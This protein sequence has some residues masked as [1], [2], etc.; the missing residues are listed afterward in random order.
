MTNVVALTSPLDRFDDVQ[1]ECVQEWDQKQLIAALERASLLDLQKL[2]QVQ[3]IKASTPLST[4]RGR[5]MPPMEAVENIRI[6]TGEGERSVLEFNGVQVASVNVSD[7]MSL[8]EMYAKVKVVEEVSRQSGRNVEIHMA[9]QHA[10]D[11]VHALSTTCGRSS[12]NL[13]NLGVVVEKYHL[14]RRMF[15]RVQPCYAVKSNP[16]DMICRT[17]HVAGAGFDCASQVELEQVLRLPGV[18]VNDI[19]FAN[20]CKQVAHIEYAKAHGVAMM[21][22]DNPYELEKIHRVYPEAKL[23]LRLLPDDSH[24]L[25]PFGSKFGASFSEAQA[26]IAQCKSLGMS[27][28]GVS[29]HVGS[30]CY[31]SV[32]WIEALKLS[33]QVFDEAK[34]YGYYMTLVDMGGGFPG[35]ETGNLPLAHIG[36]QVSPVI[37]QLF[38]P[39]IRVIAEPGRFFCTQSTTLACTVVS[40]R[41]RMVAIP[42]CNNN[43]NNV[44][45]DDK[46]DGAAAAPAA[47]TTLEPEFQLYLSDGIYG[48]MNCVVFDHAVLEPLS[49]SHALKAQAAAANAAQA[50]IDDND[51]NN[52]NDLAQQLVDVT[53]TTVD[54]EVN[55]NNNDESGAS[56]SSTTSVAPT[57]LQRTTMW[58]PTCDSI[59]VVVKGIPFPDT[60]VG[61]WIYFENMGAYTTAA[62]SSFNGFAPPTAFYVLNP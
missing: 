57:P 42:V 34:K 14:W 41:E 22:F 19:V 37:D 32:A 13:V 39:E 38:G 29:F 5:F 23:I 62:A 44:A 31:S 45:V 61:E 48:S 28:I 59:D 47:T 17:L 11:Q 8:V 1:V 4:R 33:R 35:V 20:P 51:N 50:N 26:L 46:H 10:P 43:N 21:T 40:K 18:D 52:N 24:S 54:D 27:L 7:V 3:P 15:P 16:D 58:G 25:M 53:I 56:P 60:Q 2:L 6:I 36:P 12:F 30:G 9:P 55:N 49:L